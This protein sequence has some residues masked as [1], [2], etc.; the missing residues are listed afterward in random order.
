MSSKSPKTSSP[1]E[2]AGTG[3]GEPQAAEGGEGEIAIEVEPPEPGPEQRIA[4]L[5]ARVKEAH[6]KYLR[7]AA[8]LDNVR[9]RTRKEMED[10]RVDAQSRVLRE[11]LPVIDNL[12]RAVAHAAQSGD[13]A[14]GVLEGIQLVLRQ[15]AQ[16]LERCNVHAVEAR[17][18][19]FD[20]NQHEAVSQVVTADAP[21]GSVVEVMQTG[22]RIGERLLRPAL[23]VVAK[24]PPAPAD[25]EP[26][27]PNGRDPSAES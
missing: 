16:A 12:E 2:D 4:E 15:F 22:Y 9:K 11:M 19:P 13:G 14:S 18:L 27:G 17:G 3:A 26:A 23:V 24:A 25:D 10:A 20:P 8:E 6:D 5:E 7:S 21:A 1:P